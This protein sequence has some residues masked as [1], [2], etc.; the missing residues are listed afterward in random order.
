MIYFLLHTEDRP[1]PTI[2]PEGM[3][4][5]PEWHQENY[6]VEDIIEA[7][8]WIAAKEKLG[9]QLTRLQRRILDEGPG[10]LRRNIFSISEPLDA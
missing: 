7:P 6:L 8:S 10:F 3:L 9:F 5:L 1:G 2:L 4:E